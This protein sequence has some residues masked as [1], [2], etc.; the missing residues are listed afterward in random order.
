MP[1]T[2]PW[3]AEAA[4]AWSDQHPPHKALWLSSGSPEVRIYGMV[5]LPRGYV[6]NGL[7]Q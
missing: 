7:H 4:M 5:L 6:V 1:V 2:G 3:A